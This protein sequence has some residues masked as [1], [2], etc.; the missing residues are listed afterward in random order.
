MTIVL[1][2]I[3]LLAA[4]LA[5]GVGELCARLALPGWLCEIIK[6]AVLLLCF[7]WLQAVL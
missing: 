3:C 5:V 6:L 4:L 7:V 1:T 2:L